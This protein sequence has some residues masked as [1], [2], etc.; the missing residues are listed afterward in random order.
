MPMI[1]D[2]CRTGPSPLFT[3][4][5][6]TSTRIWSMVSKTDC[7]DAT[8]GMINALFILKLLRVLS[9]RLTPRRVR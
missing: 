6:P 1:A 8:N 5:V 2:T 3:Y 4:G 7:T 9:P